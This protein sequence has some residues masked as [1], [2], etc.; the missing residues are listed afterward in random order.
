MASRRPS[1]RYTAMTSFRGV[2][3][4]LGTFDTYERARVAEKLFYLWARRGV[5][6]PRAPRT[7]DA[8]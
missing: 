2:G 4:H 1:G 3:I 6:M 5:E 7:V 8:I